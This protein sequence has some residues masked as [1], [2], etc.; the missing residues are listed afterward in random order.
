MAAQGSGS[1]SAS[2]EAPG[3]L[4]AA[5]NSAGLRAAGRDPQASETVLVNG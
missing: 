2:Q 1:L 3:S 5:G 4:S